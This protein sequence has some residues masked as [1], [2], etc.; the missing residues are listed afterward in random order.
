MDVFQ[1]WA[2]F[3]IQKKDKKAAVEQVPAKASVLPIIMLLDGDVEMLASVETSLER[4]SHKRL[5]HHVS[6]AS[7]LYAPLLKLRCNCCK[8]EMLS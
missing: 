7:V 1:S 2:A 8:I 5:M 4:C 6:N 3:T